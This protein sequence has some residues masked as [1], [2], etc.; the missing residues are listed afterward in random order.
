MISK[1]LTQKQTYCAIFIITLI[2]H[3]P[4]LFGLDSDFQYYAL[5]AKLLSLGKSPYTHFFDHKPPLFF[6]ALL[7]G[8]WIGGSF[9]HYGAIYLGYLSITYTLLFHVGKKLGNKPNNYRGLMGCLL[10][11]TLTL[12][13]HLITGGNLNGS[14]IIFSIFFNLYA[15]HITLGILQNKRNF[16]GTDLIKN[17]LLLGFLSGLSFITRF[18]VVPIGLF[19]LLL[20]IRLVKKKTSLIQN[21]KALLIFISAFL[22]SIMFVYITSQ[23]NITAIVQ[24][25]FT[26]NVGYSNVENLSHIGTFIERSI[27]SSLYLVNYTAPLIAI[28]LGII[29][30]I[31][32]TKPIIKNQTESWSSLSWLSLYFFG[33]LIMIILQNMGQ[34]NYIYFPIFI[35][36]CLIT[37]LLLTD[38]LDTCFNTK[39]K[40]SLPFL[41]ILI[42]ASLIIVKSHIF[43]IHQNDYN[44]Y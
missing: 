32:S 31:L 40:K 21:I 27:K 33:E 10:F 44:S 37:S 29:I 8:K 39:E 22:P 35:P 14:I 17:S 1:F 38:F 24:N 4:I 42:A 43:Y 26:T 28:A 20:T 13:Q 19:T 9:F 16:T 11:A 15:F 18:S 12:G 41:I 3:I 6:Y 30:W 23:K 25:L 2:V 5:H 36:L 7:P 34:K